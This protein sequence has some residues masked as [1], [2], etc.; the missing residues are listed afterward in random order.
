MLFCIF[1]LR[2]LF[3]HS[4]SAKKVELSV[5][6]FLLQHHATLS[7]KALWWLIKEERAHIPDTCLC[8]VIVITKDTIIGHPVYY[9]VFWHQA[10]GS[11]AQTGHPGSFAR[12]GV[13]PAKDFL[14]NPRDLPLNSSG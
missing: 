11:V 6:Q 9:K 12:L 3:R 5:A 10:H 13:T 14:Y 4:G 7:S 1:V 8:D 2:S